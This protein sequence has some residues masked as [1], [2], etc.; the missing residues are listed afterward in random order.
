MNDRRNVQK[1]DE[2]YAAFGRGD[3][4]FILDQLAEDVR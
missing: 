4:G 1:I 3:I 2:L